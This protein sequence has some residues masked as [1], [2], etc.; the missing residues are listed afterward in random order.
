MTVP[1]AFHTGRLRF[2]ARQLQRFCAAAS[3]QRVGDR[4]VFVARR[5]SDGR[6]SAVVS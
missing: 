5:S 3:V 6:L 4:A 1:A 2:V